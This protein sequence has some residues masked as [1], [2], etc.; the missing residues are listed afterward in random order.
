MVKLQFLTFSRPYFLTCS[1]SLFALDLNVTPARIEAALKIA[2]GS[3]SSRLAFHRPYIF[4]PSDPSIARI[5][6][7]TEF[8]RIVLMAEE[9]IARGDR[10]F[11][12][13]AQQ[14]QAAIQP[15]R[16]RVSLVAEVRFH[17]QNAYVRPPGIDVILAGS[18]GDLMRIDL[19][20]EP[21]YAT[22]GGTVG[23]RAPLSGVIGEAVFDASVVG[24]AFRTASV[25]LDGDLLASVPIDFSRLD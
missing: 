15:W 8:R 25:R 3:E 19:R 5:E 20:N 14:A 18:T 6:A 9:R 10:L 24:Q 2:R 16:G 17:P 7:I 13:S 11:A 21:R 12:Q 23:S 4:Q 22:F 1:L